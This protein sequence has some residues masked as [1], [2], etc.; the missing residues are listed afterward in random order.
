MT[1]VPMAGLRKSQAQ[2]EF[3]Q[4]THAT[5]RAIA[6]ELTM[7]KT[8]GYMTYTYDD[9]GNR[10]TMAVGNNTT[11]YT[12]DAANKMLTAGSSTFTYDDKGNTTRIV[13]GTITTD[14]T[15]DLQNRM[16]QWSKTSQT[17][18]TYLYN[19]DGTRVRKTPNGG[20]QTDFL[21]DMGEIAE[22]ITGSSI[23]SYVGP[24]LISKISGTTRAIYHSDGVGSTRAIS[25]EN[26]AVAQAEIFD[27]YGNRLAPS[28]STPS[29][30]FAG[31]YRYYADATGLDYLKARYYD[32][33]D[34]SF[35]SRDPIG[36]NGG[37]N[38]YAYMDG[39]PVNGVDPLGLS[40]E[41]FWDCY[42]K[43]V[44]TLGPVTRI[45]K[46]FY[47]TTLVTVTSA[48]LVKT[49]ECKNGTIILVPR[50]KWA[51]KIIPVIRWVA[52]WVIVPI[53]WGEVNIRA[54]C[55]ATCHSG[56]YQDAWGLQ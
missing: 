48:I 10:L 5:R 30:G 26:E 45:K 8:L 33:S 41:S 21:L 27:A 1:I 44:N 36:L 3:W 38:L 49:Y 12:Y 17:T 47:Y 46:W 39:D 28:G 15:W 50:W 22:E 13:A 24:G 7:E 55:W 53:A 16:T 23:A 20:T 42:N 9:A 31:Q 34:G 2:E 32:P 4:T 11:N 56:W 25:D 54:M 14:Y 18:E 35:L 29:F 37:L 19:A 40:S 43:C 51:K 52:T 6:R